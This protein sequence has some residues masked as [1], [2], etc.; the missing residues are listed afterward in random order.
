MSKISTVDLN[1]PT[2]GLVAPADDSEPQPVAVGE[3]ESVDVPA[4]DE[5]ADIDTDEL[6]ALLVDLKKTKKLNKSPPKKRVRKPKVNDPIVEVPVAAVEPVAMVPIVEE[7]VVIAPVAVEPK[8]KRKYVRKE[9][10]APESV[11]EPVAPQATEEPVR[12]AGS[13]IEEMQRAERALRYQMRKNK[14]QT[15]V[16]HAF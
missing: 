4:H 16:S 9:N 11:P 6:E 15:L 13:M 12:R 2:A 14:M 1:E 8:S 5:A 7:P 3:P 10:K